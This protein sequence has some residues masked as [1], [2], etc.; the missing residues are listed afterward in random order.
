[1]WQHHS[2]SLVATVWLYNDL[3]RTLLNY[4][5]PV[6][7]ASRT[8]KK[9]MAEDDIQK[10]D[11]LEMDTLIKKYYSNHSIILLKHHSL[12]QTAQGQCKWEEC[13]TLTRT[14][15]EFDS[16]TVL[17]YVKLKKCIWENNN[18]IWGPGITNSTCSQR[19]VEYCFG[20]HST[21]MMEW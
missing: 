7:I 2:Q 13:A 19:R 9:K 16:M 15:F 18:A 20:T 4:H 14:Y 12:C 3:V 8:M 1:M 6:I 21:V 10:K 5:R 11:Q 17:T